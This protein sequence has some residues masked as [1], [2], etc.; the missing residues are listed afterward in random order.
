[1]FNLKKIFA[2]SFVANSAIL[3]AGGVLAQIVTFVTFI[4]LA[5]LFSTADFGNYSILLGIS[6]IAAPLL[7]W[8][9]EVALVL[10]KNHKL[11]MELFLTSLTLTLMTSLIAFGILSLAKHLEV[12]VGELRF[13]KLETSLVIY[14]MLLTSC[15][16]IT[17]YMALSLERFMLI[18]IMPI[19]Q[20]I[21]FLIFSISL[22]YIIDKDELITAA[23]FASLISLFVYLFYLS[24]NLHC[25]NYF[26]KYVLK[27]YS[28]VA[29]FG[30]PS[31][32]I[33]NVLFHMPLFCIVFL[34]DASVAGLYGMVS[35]V[36]FAPLSIFSRSISQVHF[37][38]YADRLAQGQSGLSYMFTITAFITLIGI[39]PV[40]IFYT[41]GQYLF[42]VG[43]GVEW[44]KAGVMLEILSFAILLKF[45]AST[46]SPVFTASNH[47]SLFFAL[48]LFTLISM[49]I[50][51]ML[52]SHTQDYLVLIRKLAVFESIMA[53]VF[54]LCILYAVKNP[55]ER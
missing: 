1:M 2:Q 52:Y 20:A 22:Y 41:S 3:I 43:F 21:S 53:S 42:T 51:F 31:I 34:Y 9:Y 27:K 24:K 10:E 7:T 6:S 19:F 15:L 18:G 30:S 47:L 25:G 11:R 37:K 33:D 55:K 39:V 46:L 32:L 35:R 40:S 14:M 16:S 45:I 8:R 26:S 29:L 23:I 38:A 44:E 13:V 12:K 17:R 36:A 28:D 5:R 48:K 49:L 50:F 54:L 4:I